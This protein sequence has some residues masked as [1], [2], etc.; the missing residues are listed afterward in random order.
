MTET[1]LNSENLSGFELYEKQQKN[2]QEQKEIRKSYGNKYQF[3]RNTISVVDTLFRRLE[4]IQKDGNFKTKGDLLEFLVRLQEE[5]KKNNMIK[6]IYKCKKCGKPIEVDS[7]WDLSRLFHRDIDNSEECKNCNGRIGKSY[8]I[9]TKI[10]VLP[11]I[12]GAKSGQTGQPKKI[13]TQSEPKK[14]K[15]PS[16]MDDDEFAGYLFRFPQDTWESHRQAR[17]DIMSKRNVEELRDI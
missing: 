10:G 12:T 4:A 11:G 2:N 13:E 15:D 9:M 6:D 14:P 16:E 7:K 17:K 5:S 3:N 1:E 8:E